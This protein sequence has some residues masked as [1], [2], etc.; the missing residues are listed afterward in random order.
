M[1]PKIWE[2]FVILLGEN[3]STRLFK[4]RPIWSHCPWPIL[5][6]LGG[7]SMTSSK[8]I[9][10]KKRVLFAVYLC[11]FDVRRSDLV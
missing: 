9:P 1:L 10:T 3:L 5:R 11:Y 4:N 6:G 2:I 8:A 7:H